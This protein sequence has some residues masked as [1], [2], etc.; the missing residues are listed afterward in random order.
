MA[1]NPR[2]SE[3]ASARSARGDKLRV[4]GLIGWGVIIGALLVWEGLGL[5]YDHGRWPTLSDMLRTV[6]A[7]VPGRWILFAL[8]LWAGWHMFVRGWQFFLRD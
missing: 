8:W 6:T 3:P 2:R 5:V 7:T 1:F 4:I